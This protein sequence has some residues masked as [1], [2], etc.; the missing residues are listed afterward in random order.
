MLGPKPTPSG[1]D[2]TRK[3]GLDKNMKSKIKNSCKEGINKEYCCVKETNWNKCFVY[4]NHFNFANCPF[5]C[6]ILRSS[7]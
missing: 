7:E 1:T 4:T 6:A 2:L 5:S 3:V